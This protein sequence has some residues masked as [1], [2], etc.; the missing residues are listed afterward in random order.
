[1]PWVARRAARSSVLSVSMPPP[2]KHYLTTR[3]E[4]LPTQY[5]RQNVVSA[6]A[7]IFRVRHTRAGV[8]STRATGCAC[9]LRPEQLCA[10]SINCTTHSPGV[11][12]GIVVECL[13]LVCNHLPQHL[14]A[15]QHV[16]LQRCQCP[17]RVFFGPGRHLPT[18][19]K[20]PKFPPFA[21]VEISCYPSPQTGSDLENLCRGRNGV[22]RGQ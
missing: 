1:M 14:L 2:G 16:P 5:R 4:W 17:R 21:T 7:K 15:R 3:I 19:E 13:P 11:R 20:A 22:G 12:G 9:V 6:A 18:P 8:R 10:L